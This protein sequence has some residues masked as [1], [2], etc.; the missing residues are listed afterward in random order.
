MGTSP[1]DFFGSKENEENG[2]KPQ[3]EAKSNMS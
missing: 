2:L 3:S 1:I